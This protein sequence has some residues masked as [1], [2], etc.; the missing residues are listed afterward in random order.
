MAVAAVVDCSPDVTKDTSKQRCFGQE[1]TDHLT[2]VTDTLPAGT[3][4]LVID[5]ESSNAFTFSL[6]VSVEE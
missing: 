5:G 4:N 2:M 6:K 3:Y 1:N